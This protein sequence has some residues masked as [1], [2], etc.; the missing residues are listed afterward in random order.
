[1]PILPIAGVECFAIATAYLTGSLARRAGRA[2]RSGRLRRSACRLVGQRFDFF[3]QAG[4]PDGLGVVL[5]AAGLEGLFS[6]AGECM[7][8][9]GDDG[10]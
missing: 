3:E 10:R 6:V 1:V 8:S 7:C 5:V 4:Q 2:V 9:E